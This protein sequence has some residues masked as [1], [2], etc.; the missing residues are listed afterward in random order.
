MRFLHPNDELLGVL[1]TKRT[2]KNVKLRTPR[3]IYMLTKIHVYGILGIG[4]C[5]YCQQLITGALE[6]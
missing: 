3:W 6:D 5:K 1:A 2:D 4:G